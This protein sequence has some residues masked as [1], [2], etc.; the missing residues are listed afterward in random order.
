MNISKK[1]QATEILDKINTGLSILNNIDKARLS[2]NIF[3]GVFIPIFAGEKSLY[4]A[5]IETWINFAG[6]P[7]KEVDIIDN[8]GNVL[9]TV[10]AIYDR[11]YVKSITDR[12]TTSISHIVHAA[13][14][15]ARIHPNQ[16]RAYM[17]N[18]LAKKASILNVPD[19]VLENLEF[20]NMVFLKYGR[21]AIVNVDEIKEE[22]NTGKVD[23][24]DFEGF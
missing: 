2:E 4:N 6:S 18:E 8:R 20:W 1:D 9:Y 10:P 24:D 3:V 14:Q 23:P 5:T 7:Y 11:T 17:R 12:G 21:K 15:F 22:S 16:G 13:N 19:G